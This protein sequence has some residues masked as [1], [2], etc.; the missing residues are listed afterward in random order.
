MTMSSS[1]LSRLVRPYARRLNWI[2][3]IN[4][5]LGPL[6]L[7]IAFY[8]T[9]LILVKMLHPEGLGW[10]HW[11]LALLPL[12]LLAGWFRARRRNRFYTTEEIIEILD[13]YYRAD[14]SVS[15]AY[16]RAELIPH[17]PEYLEEFQRTIRLR[18]PTVSLMHYLR[19]VAPAMVY[20]LVAI[21]LPPREPEAALP[22]EAVV[23]SLTQPLVEELE[24]FESILPEAEEEQ[25]REALETLRESE[26]GIS[27]EKW[28]AIEAIEQRIDDA[29]AE[30]RQGLGEVAGTLAMMSHELEEKGAL[31]EELSQA[32]SQQLGEQLAAHAV[33]ADSPLGEQLR[34][35]QGNLSGKPMD[36]E[37]LRRK[38]E[39][40][41]KELEAK[42]CKPSQCPGGEC[43][44]ICQSGYCTRPGRGSVD[45]GRGDAEMTFD[46]RRELNVFQTDSAI[47]STEFMD[48]EHLVDLGL[49]RIEPNPD[50]GRFSPSMV[51]SF[52]AQSGS[53]AAKT[54]IGPAQR[55]VI[56]RYFSDER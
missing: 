54:R 40:L 32:L 2:T 37:A 8:A 20:V 38:L 42:G 12:S 23:E 28:E 13:H 30:Q 43:M 1:E 18:F 49:K 51:R 4:E 31:G 53:Q 34:E 24:E 29:V 16:E 5:S 11:P 47:L 45:R 10:A 3:W 33:A 50:P 6:I 55:G 14:G 35:F 25:L 48:Q 9:T 7:L 17:L 19:R 41:K 52:E 21:V 26:E 15:T 36:P 46:E 56:E 44:G 27:R 39:A 22:A